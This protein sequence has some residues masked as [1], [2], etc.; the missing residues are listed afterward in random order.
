M[1]LTLLIMWAVIDP[2]M[3]AVI[4]KTQ[5]FSVVRTRALSLAFW[6]P[7]PNLVRRGFEL[8]QT[9][10]SC[11]ASWDCGDV[12]TRASNLASW[13]YSDSRTQI[14]SRIL[15]ITVRLG[16][17]LRPSRLG[18]VLLL[19]HGLHA[20]R[21]GITRVAII[22]LSSGDYPLVWNIDFVLW[23]LVFSDF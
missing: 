19:R 21:L 3:R 11:S 12:K 13:C 10:A 15:I 5:S 4:T 1:G 6:M 14:K 8:C 16:C 23:W 20:L 22:S 2:V 17:G 18:T 9:R 7:T